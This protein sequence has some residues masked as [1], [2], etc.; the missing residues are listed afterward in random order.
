MNDRAMQEHSNTARVS[1]WAMAALGDDARR[2]GISASE[3]AGHVLL[4][5]RDLE[6]G[7]GWRMV[8]LFRWVSVPEVHERI[9]KTVA[10]RL[11]HSTPSPLPRQGRSEASIVEAGERARE[12]MA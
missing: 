7:D 10:Y 4:E 6:A 12:S 2:F 1:A 5:L 11:R 3:E 8:L 9:R